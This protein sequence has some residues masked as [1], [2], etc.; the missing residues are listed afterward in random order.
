MIFIETTIR[1][2][3]VWLKEIEIERFEHF[4]SRQ[5]IFINDSRKRMLQ[6]ILIN[7]QTKHEDCKDQTN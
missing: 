4:T 6:T 7:D 2:A 1:V 3:S 5:K